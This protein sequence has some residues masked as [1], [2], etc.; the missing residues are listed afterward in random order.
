MS[1]EELRH[2]S[3]RW[4]PCLLGAPSCCVKRIGAQPSYFSLSCMGENSVPQT[5]MKEAPCVQTFPREKKFARLGMRV[6][7]IPRTS[8]MPYLGVWLVVHQ[9]T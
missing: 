6:K 2:T 3:G 9:P 7:I 1:P 5:C 8:Q 4:R